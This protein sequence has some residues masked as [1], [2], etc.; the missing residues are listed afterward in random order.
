MIPVLIGAYAAAI[1]IAPTSTLKIILGAPVLL[2][3]AAFWTIFSERRWIVMLFFCAVLLPPL[4][5]PIG[6]T[7]PHPALAVVALGLCAGLVRL[8]T[9]TPADRFHFVV[10]RSVRHV[11]IVRLRRPE[12]QD[13]H[14]PLLVP[15]EGVILFRQH[16]LAHVPLGIT[17]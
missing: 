11:E 3:P 1:A 7:G 16:P 12:R 14:L 10:I 8:L 13:G 15:D 4:P 2:A 17:T 9:R 5:F 6:D